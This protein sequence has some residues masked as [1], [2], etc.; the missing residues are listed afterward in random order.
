MSNLHHSSHSRS[1]LIP[2][3]GLGTR[4]GLG[5]KCLLRLGEKSLLE[6]LIDTLSPLVDEIVI[7]TP[8]DFRDEITAITASRASIICGGNSRQSSIDKLLAASTENTVLIQDAARPFASAQLCAAVLEAAEQHG[9]AGAFLDPTVPIGHLQ[10]DTVASFYSRDEA[11]IF[12]APQAFNRQL[13]T[14][15]RAHA[16]NQEFQSTAQMVMDAGHSL[17]AVAG[18]PE[19]IK[20]TTPLDWQIARKVIASKLGLNT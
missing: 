15:A 6:I 5:P 9:A 16:G 11:R 19:N 3:A 8:A 17:L 20:I 1:A 10:G 14:N 13:L 7:A 2:A 12:Q 18:E 4:L